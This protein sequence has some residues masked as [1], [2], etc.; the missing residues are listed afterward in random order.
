MDAARD[1]AWAKLDRKAVPNQTVH[2]SFFVMIT[3]GGHDDNVSPETNEKETT[4]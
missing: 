2:P 4:V 3:D 1:L